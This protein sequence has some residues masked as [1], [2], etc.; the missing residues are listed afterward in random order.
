ME[1]MRDLGAGQLD[2][3]D[4]QREQIRNVLQGHR[5]EQRQIAQRLRD[6]RKQ[7]DDAV[8]STAFDEA[9]IRARSADVGAV[10][11]DAAV[12]RAKVRGEIWSLL[13]AEQQQKA[14]EL[15]AKRAERRQ[16]RLEQRKQRQQQRQR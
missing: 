3:T 11:A 9:A 7:L 6:A 10:Q 16:Q 5:D 2:L 4:A 14:T 1:V 12:L 15:R 13:T 8:A